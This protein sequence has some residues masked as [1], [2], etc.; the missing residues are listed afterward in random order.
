[1][2]KYSALWFGLLAGGLLAIGRSFGAL[3]FGIVGGIAVSFLRPARQAAIAAVL[4]AL[5]ITY[6]QL[7]MADLIP[8]DDLVAWIQENVSEQR[9][10]SLNFRFV[11]ELILAERANERMWFGWGLYCRPCVRDPETGRRS[12]VADGEWV[13]TYGSRGLLGFLAFFGA[14]VLPL[15][16][17]WWKLGMVPDPDD[18]KLLAGLSLIVALNLVDLIPNSLFAPALTLS[19]VGAL[20]A[21]SQTLPDP[22]LASENDQPFARFASLIGRMRAA[23]D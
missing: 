23:S 16:T 22:D 19:I 9:A 2:G 11:N 18:R 12:S 5:V 13:I 15:F 4:G 17:T 20:Y 6:P 7:R 21:F 3:M 14:L 8:T 10:G 1:M